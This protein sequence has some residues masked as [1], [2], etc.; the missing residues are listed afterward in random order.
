MLTKR[1]QY[2]MFI[3]LMCTF[4]FLPVNAQDD[5]EISGW[6]T[7]TAEDAPP[8]GDLITSIVVAHDNTVWVGTWDGIAHYDGE[9][10]TTYSK[11]DEP[12]SKYVLD[13]D[14]APNGTVWASLDSNIVYFDGNEWI[15]QREGLNH[16]NPDQ[17]RTIIHTP[18]GV[19]WISSNSGIH[20]YDGQL[21]ELVRSRPGVSRIAVA[22]DGTL[23]VARFEGYC[24]RSWVDKFDGE[25]WTDFTADDGV[26]QGCLFS[27]SVA[28][29]SS[30]WLVY[31]EV[32][33]AAKSSRGEI[34]SHGVIH[35][36][37][38]NWTQYSAEDHPALAQAGEVAVSPDGCVWVTTRE[39]GVLQFDGETWTQF[40]TEDGL[41]DNVTS[42]IAVASDGTVW[43]GTARG[44]SRYIPP[45]D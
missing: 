5:G 27:L 8:L 6:T 36:D 44:V 4:M 37:S 45:Q 19:T 33:W 10:W 21:W 1:F 35:F 14:I 9:T 30:L 15:S 2:L 43:I 31:E 28:P 39:N 29:D 13:M 18:D 42:A 20:R 32:V 3:L 41:V 25:T 38:E 26:V 22:P 40:T 24:L 17:Y 16:G 12:L 34:I 11:D 23:W 7:F